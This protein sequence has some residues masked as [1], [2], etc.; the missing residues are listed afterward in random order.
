MTRET[1]ARPLYPQ[2]FWKE[3]IPWL[4]EAYLMRTVRVASGGTEA[5]IPAQGALV[6]LFAPHSGWVEAVVIDEYLRRVGRHP[7][8]W[9]TKRDN[10]AVPRVLVGDRLI[11]MDRAYPEPSCIRAIYYVLEQRDAVIAS[12]IEGSRFGNPEDRRDLLVLGG[13]KTGMVRIAVKAQVPILPIIV[14]G[15]EK[16]SPW[17]DEIWREQGIPSAHREIRRLRACPQPIEV[18]FLS[19][20]RDHI[21]E[22]RDLVGRRLREKAELHTRSLGE[23]FRAKILAL[24]PDYP[25]GAALRNSVPPGRS[26]RV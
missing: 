17:L 15:A 24:V 2:P 26:V 6:A 10:L 20:F 4:L 3:I 11:C 25:L 18:R 12:S 16:V 7:A 19:P 13:F 9:V 1:S 5:N 23:A 22:G 8:V 14:L 21:G